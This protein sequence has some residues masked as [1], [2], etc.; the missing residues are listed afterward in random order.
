MNTSKH[1]K[2]ARKFLV[3]DDHEAVLEG[4]VSS[5][6]QQYPDV[7][8]L[9]AQ[10][11]ES[12]LQKIKAGDIDLLIMDLSIPRMIGGIARTENGIQ[13][14][15]D[16]LHAYPTLNVL[17]QSAYTK[18]LVR[19]K[20]LINIHEGGFTIADK[21][22]PFR[23]MLTK[24]DW[25]LQGLIYTPREMR[26]GLELKPEWIEVLNL[27]FEQGL[28]DKAIAEYMNVAERTVRHYWT[29]VQ[30]ALGVYPETGKNIR[31]Q[32]EIRAREEGLID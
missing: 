30:D 3:V 19:L 20:P 14:L 1:L 22:L 25:S 32:T 4:T 21:S 7:E 11:A 27:A 24:V 8:M 10:T 26:S 23:E 28:Q 15:R 9:M 2:K 12:T 31:I 29:Q 6:K 16:I 5:L 13:L 18:A 17:V